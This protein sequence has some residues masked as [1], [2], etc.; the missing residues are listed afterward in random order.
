MVNIKTYSEVIREATDLDRRLLNEL[1][2]GAPDESKVKELLDEGASPNAMSDWEH[3]LMFGMRALGIAVKECST[4]IINLLLDEGAKIEEEDMYGNT[5]LCVAV[6][7]GLLPEMR[8]LMSRGA[9]TNAKIGGQP[10][11]IYCILES[12]IDSIKALIEGGANVDGP[13]W[14]GFT[15]LTLAAKVGAIRAMDALVEA[16]ADIEKRD[17]HGKTP[18]QR[19]KD[20]ED[21]LSMQGQTTYHLVRHMINIGAN[22]FSAFSNSKEIIDFFNGDIEWMP[23]GVKANLERM[24]KTRAMF[25]R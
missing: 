16:G 21:E 17:D 22:P 19:A 8:L 1:S 20:L 12:R 2:K 11:L 10:L 3:A 13:T 4:R 24:K 6:R 9:N 15:P 7:F 14:K 23:E 5:P 18:M 25:R